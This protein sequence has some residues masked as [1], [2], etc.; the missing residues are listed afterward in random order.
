MFRTL[1]TG[2]A[3][4]RYVVFDSGHVPPRDDMIREALDWLDR[5]LAPV[6]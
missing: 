1:G 5:Y 4:K 6:R 2:S 3:D